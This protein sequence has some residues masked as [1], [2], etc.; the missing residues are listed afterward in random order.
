MTAT[1]QAIRRHSNDAILPD[2][3]PL[4]RVC[5]FIVDGA[6]LAS[7]LIVPCLLGGRIAIGQMGLAG[8]AGVA[9]IAWSVSLLCGRRPQ[10]AV[11]WCEPIL[12]AIIGLGLLQMTPMPSQLV[13]VLSPHQ[14]ELLPLW[15]AATDEISLGE[16]R[17]LSLH[18]S[19]TRSALIVGISYVLL[20]YVATQRIRR[21]RDVERFLC[22]IA[23]ASGAMAFFGVVQW[24]TSNGKFF[25]FYDYPLTDSSHR[26]KG[27]F[28]NRNHFA[29]F[30]ALGCGPMLL[31][32]VRLLEKRLA[33]TTQ[34]GTAKSRQSPN[35]VMLAVLLLTLGVLVFAVLFSLSRG[36]IVALSVA[37]VF[38]LGML[39]QIGR[40]SGKM[41]SVLMGIGVVAGS[42][43]AMFG[44]EKVAQRL[45]HWQSDSRLAIW[46]A[47]LN[48]ISHFPLFGTG[49]GSHA[50]AYPVYF[51]PPFGETEFTH[52]ENS[53][54]Q[55]A[56][57]TGLAGLTLALLSMGCCVVWC[58]RSLRR[59]SDDRVRLFAAA[60]AA[61][62]A[63]NVV[64]ATFDFLWYVPG[65]MTTV[66]LLA[67]CARR[68]DQLSY[69]SAAGSGHVPH[70][71]RGSSGLLLRGMGFLVVCSVVCVGMWSIPKL[72]QAMAGEPHWFD[73]LRIVLRTDDDATSDLSETESG[74]ESAQQ[75]EV[76]RFKR[77]MAALSQAIKAN[78]QQARAHLRLATSYLT[79]FEH[80][81]RSSENPMSLSTLRDTALTSNFESTDAMREWLKRAVGPNM[82]YL[83]AAH[84]HARRAIQLCP[85][86][87]QGYVRLSELAFLDSLATEQT[88]ELLI[89]AERVRPYSAE[90]QFM[91]GREALFAGKLEEAMK[92]WRN[93]FHHDHG[94][95][96]QIL[97]LLVGVAPAELIVQ[98]LQPD[99]PA[100][101]SLE[102]RFRAMPPNEYAVIG[103]ALVE[104]LTAEADNLQCD[105]PIQRILSAADVSIRMN[106]AAGAESSYRRALEMD[107]NSYAARKAFGLF[108]F[109]QKQFQ[110]A[111]EHLQWCLKINSSDDG[112]RKIAEQ[113]VAQSFGGSSSIQPV[114]Y[115]SRSRRRM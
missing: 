71:N 23:C 46:Q 48:V 57:E 13:N 4:E 59:R 2:R 56:S 60:I 27:A 92:S 81:Q 70:A 36:G 3:S 113:A 5:D 108:L 74:V 61:S 53:Y 34:F 96:Q 64:H 72:H 67:A 9:A 15:N 105:Q 10:W 102:V 82:R 12:L 33:A 54:L 22:W 86:Q 55:V 65:L 50:E 26:M 93:A 114:E 42:L 17:T 6:L 52:A 89:Q 63:A 66:I 21:I 35:D 38:M 104:S 111:T 41:I 115:Q 69:P 32:I 79:A 75:T 47:N 68:L 58:W 103:R 62:L 91:V 101:E 76:A 49:M 110:R 87:G 77:R 1:P 30:L 95:Q 109:Q 80:L 7:V 85:L 83:D 98:Q 107:R 100:L 44:Y 25:W 8:C 20:F 106:D 43:F 97:E 99:L 112:L 28:T 19:E 94:F 37:M 14:R 84:K 39:Y 90:V 78:P 51:D 29:Q 45:D 88:R 11:T 16:W 73:Y 31:W 18:P 24:L 40:L